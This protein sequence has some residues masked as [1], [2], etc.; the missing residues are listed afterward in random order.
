MMGFLHN[1]GIMIV[2]N[3]PSQSPDLNVIENM[4]MMVGDRVERQSFENM[5]LLWQSIR[6]DFYAIPDAVVQHLFD[7]IPKRMKA[8][9]KKGR[10]RIKYH[11]YN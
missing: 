6:G 4:W 10:Y 11:Y 9:L 1:N 5:D 7:L 8:V 2:N 3:W